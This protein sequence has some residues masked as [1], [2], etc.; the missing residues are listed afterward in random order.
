MV[1]F[2][3]WDAVVGKVKP[4]VSDEKLVKGRMGSGTVETGRSASYKR[5]KDVLS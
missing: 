4:P 2:N 1:K 3:S 5:N